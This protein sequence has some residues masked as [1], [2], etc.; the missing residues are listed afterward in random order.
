[1]EW[2]AL[3]LALIATLLQAAEVYLGWLQV[4]TFKKNPSRSR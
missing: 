2:A 3:V 4:F 1:M